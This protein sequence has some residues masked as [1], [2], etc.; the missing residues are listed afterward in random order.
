MEGIADVSQGAIGP[1][2]GPLANRTNAFW[3]FYA[4][5]QNMN[6]PSDYGFL[7]ADWQ[8][9]GCLLPPNVPFESRRA[10]TFNLVVGDVTGITGLMQVYA[11]AGA[12]ANAPGEVAIASVT[13][14]A[15]HSAHFYLQPLGD[16]TLDSASGHD[17]LPSAASPAPDV[18]PEPAS[19]VLVGSGVA[20]MIARRRRARI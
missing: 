7:C 4:S 14:D 13:A 2:G 6:N 12:V 1:D 9:P 5:I 3:G 16:F 19:I 20:A 18:V 8:D 17:Y 15:S 10:V 11:D